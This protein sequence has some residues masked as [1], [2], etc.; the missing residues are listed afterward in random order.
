MDNLT[1]ESIAT[2]W[3]VR[4]QGDF[5]T[6][7]DQQE[8]EAWLEQSTLHKVAFLRL[9][10]VWQQ[11][12]RLKA[13]GAGVPRGFV[14]TAEYWTD[15]GAAGNSAVVKIG[16]E[17]RGRRVWYAAVASMAAA[18][19]GTLYLFLTRVEGE[20]HYTTPIGGLQTLVLADGSRVILNTNTV[21]RVSL[22]RAQRRIDL[23]AGEAYFSVAE[24]PSR[25]FRVFVS[26]KAV[27]V[28]GTDFAIRR[29]A[30]DLQLVVVSGRVRL[31]TPTS[32]PE[33]AVLSAGTVTRTL[34]SELLTNQAS[35]A[36]LHALLSWRDGFI[37]F[38]DTPLSDAVAEFNR[39][40]ARK[41]LIAD[42]SI[43][44]VRING[45][46]RSGNADAFLWLL[47]KGFPVTVEEQAQGTSL[48]RR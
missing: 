22:Q 33:G 13:L 31:T 20:T 26:H 39:Y 46:F 18:L 9:D 34:G 14:P 5:W 16:R 8:L 40:R 15:V 4:R 28:L 21:I 32:S 7:A 3:L 29:N 36:E 30:D 27:T 47:Q 11:T 6:P 44:S 35:E 42:P 1:I 45:K 2:D 19:V 37:E 10:L 17:P 43:A 23:D 12:A 48:K 25:P 41:I 38:H 24:D